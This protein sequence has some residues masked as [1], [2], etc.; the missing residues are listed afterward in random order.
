MIDQFLVY[1]DDQ[2]SNLSIKEYLN[3]LPESECVNLSF[4]IDDP[5]TVQELCEV[6]SLAPGMRLCGPGCPFDE[7]IKYD[8]YNL[9]LLT[10]EEMEEYVRNITEGIKLSL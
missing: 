2:C 8:E 4:W 3:S 5:I 9:H 1:E 6:L 7:L 10:A